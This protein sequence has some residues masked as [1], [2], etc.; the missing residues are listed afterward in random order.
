MSLRTVLL[1]VRSQSVELSNVAHLLDEVM[2]KRTSASTVHQMP[3]ASVSDLRTLNAK[4]SGIK[5]HSRPTTFA[6]RSE[7]VR[8]RTRRGHIS[9][10][11]H[12]F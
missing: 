3:T 1:K 4:R 12:G 11:A 6:F 10:I 8:N 9:C 2:K 7:A 5:T